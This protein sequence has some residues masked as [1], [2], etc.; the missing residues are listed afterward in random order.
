VKIF[1]KRL[2]IKKDAKRGRP[3]E[4]GN[5]EA[6]GSASP[7]RSVA[8]LHAL[9]CSAC[10]GNRQHHPL[11]CSR[12]RKCATPGPLRSP[13]RSVVDAHGPAR[14]RRG[15][16]SSPRRARAV[17]LFFCSAS[18]NPLSP[19]GLLNLHKFMPTN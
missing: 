7:S 12:K 1:K 3:A 13:P 8:P 17:R 10:H 14:L 11:R 2:K 9:P 5:K 18:T 4:G 19:A 6:S 16:P 15:E